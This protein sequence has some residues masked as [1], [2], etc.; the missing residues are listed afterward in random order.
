MSLNS[1]AC[2]QAG[3]DIIIEVATENEVLDYAPELEKIARIETR[4]VILTG[5]SKNSERDFVSRFFAPRA[6]INEDP[7]TGS[8]HCS[9]AVLWSKKLGKSSLGAEQLSRRRGTIELGVYPDHI[10]LIGEA[11]TFAK[12]TMNV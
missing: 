8:A 9:L 3:E 1:L 2:Y 12:G 5:P 10:S 4:G 11:I 6:G 7:V